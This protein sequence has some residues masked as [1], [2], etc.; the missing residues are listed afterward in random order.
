MPDA[1][2]HG[3]LKSLQVMADTVSRAS[4]VPEMRTVMN[5]L[6]HLRQ[7]PNYKGIGWLAAEE[8]TA[9]LLAATNTSRNKLLQLSKEVK[10]WQEARAGE[11][12]RKDP[13]CWAGCTLRQD[14]SGFR[15]CQTAF[16]VAPPFRLDDSQRPSAW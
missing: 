7:L 2:Y 6:V 1:I 5:R 10:R 16:R 8:R 15:G 9:Y 14:Y 3:E 4:A 13:D 12:G 11:D